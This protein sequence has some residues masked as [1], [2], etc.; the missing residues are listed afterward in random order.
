[1][2]KDD[3]K[4]QAQGLDVDCL[5]PSTTEKKIKGSKECSVFLYWQLSVVVS[6]VHNWGMLPLDV[7]AVSFD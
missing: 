5:I 7:K 2:D 6:F 1:V 3:T 4:K